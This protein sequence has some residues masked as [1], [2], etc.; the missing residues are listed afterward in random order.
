MRKLK[1]ITKNELKSING[2]SDYMCPDFLASTCVQW[3]GLT[4]WQQEYCPNAME[5]IVPCA[6]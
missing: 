4:R 3:C 2:G 5:E 1:K 6:C